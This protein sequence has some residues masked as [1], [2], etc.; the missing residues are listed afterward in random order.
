MLPRK[1][2]GKILSVEGTT[3]LKAQRYK[4]E[5]SSLILLA[6]K[7]WGGRMAVGDEEGKINWS[8]ITW[9]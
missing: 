6:Y 4:T 8:Q 9:T 7:I 5:L 1:K 3:Q 2:Q